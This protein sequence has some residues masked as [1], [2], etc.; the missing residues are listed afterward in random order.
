M[1]DLW[2]T[3]DGRPLYAGRDFP[4]HELTPEKF[5]DFVFA[6]M[7][8]IAG[9][10]GLRI[11][12][13]PSGTG[14]GGFDV[15]AE[16]IDSN[17]SVCIQCKRQKDKLSSPQA[18]DELAKVAARSKLEGANVAEHR[19]ICTG[20]VRTKLIAELRESSRDRIAFLA[21]ENLATANTGELS[22][23][24]KRLDEAGH[25]PREVA[26]SYVRNLDVI[27]AWSSHE[28][29]VSLSRR[30]NEILEIAER[31]FQLETVVRE[32]PRASFDRSAYIDEHLNVRLIIEP[33][34]A[35]SVLPAGVTTT[36]T[37]DPGWHEAPSPKTITNLLEL[38]E[39]E[40]G[41]VA[42]VLGNGGVGKTEALRRTRA[43]ILQA[44]SDSTLPI[45][46]PLTKYIPGHLDR[47]IEQELG[48]VHGTW[49]SLPDQIVILCDGLNECA[50]STARAFL[51]EIEL[52]LK[53]KQVACIIAMR[54]ATGRSKI[55]LPPATYAFVRV[56]S[57]T[58]IGIQHIAEATLNGENADKFL[59]NYRTIADTS[60]SPLLWTPFAVRTALK[61][62]QINAELPASLGAML[63]VLLASRCERNAEQDRDQLDPEV[64]LLLASALAFEALI[65]K[66]QL[67]CAAGEAGRWIQIAKSSCQHA[68]GVSAMSDLQIIELLIAHDL[69]R[70]SEA[71]LYGFDHHLVAGAL[72]APLLAKCWREHLHALVDQ[73]SDDAW[74]FAARLIPSD[75]ISGYLDSLFHSDLI[76]GARAARDLSSNAHQHAMAIL[77]SCVAIGAPE[78]MR[79][80]GVFAL[81][82]L[83][84][85][86][87]IILLKTMADD[88]TSDVFQAARKALAM[89]GDP[90]FLKTLLDMVEI[91]TA[92]P[93]QIS[94]GDIAV[95]QSAPLVKRLDAARQRLAECSPGNYVGESLILIAVERD[96]DDVMLIE[97][98]LLA[99][100]D[101]K[102][103]GKALHALNLVASDRAK[104]AVGVATSG[105]GGSAYKARLFRIA[106][107]AGVTIDIQ[108][109][110]QCVIAYQAA[111]E[112]DPHEGYAITQ[113]IDD[114]IANAIIPVEI[115]ETIAHEL[116][117]STGDRR[118]HLWG[119]AMSCKSAALAD[120]AASCI[121]AWNEDAWHACNYFLHHLDVAYER[122]ATLT[123]ACEAGLRR[124]PE[125]WSLRTE[126]TLALM[127][128][129]GFSEKTTALLS[130][131]VERFHRI[132]EAIENGTLASLLPDDGAML[133]DFSAH[134]NLGL[135]M[136]MANFLP[137]IAQARHALPTK[138]LTDLLRVEFHSKA[139]SEELREALSDQ[140]DDDIDATLTDI[141]DPMTLAKSLVAMCPRGAT[142]TRIK[143]LDHLL[144]T[145]HTHPAIMHQV[146]EAVESCWSQPVLEMIVKAVS[147]IPTWSDFD[148][149][150]FWTF[151]HLVGRKSSNDDE[152]AIEAAMSHAK[153]AFAKRILE[154][155]RVSA[156]QERIGL[157][158]LLP[159]P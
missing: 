92:A 157:G 66:G 138:S 5:E 22:T 88:S 77:K 87:A 133:K 148:I 72:A 6:S 15:Q 143:L 129:L 124:E 45:L 118:A 117:R 8:C 17:R 49:R 110:C 24:R 79:I 34:L 86:E 82:A 71:G 60:S 10:L 139:A 58:P 43:L 125:W 111:P 11:I 18:A 1:T 123:A 107:L 19:F 31:Y 47:V 78:P 69:L 39:I 91:M 85:P 12:G 154:L 59:H 67:E 76:L 73:V 105:D 63:E 41:G 98:H 16:L 103:W 35:P 89:T 142:E 119:L 2:D 4:F 68:L 94:G 99:A 28:F 150:I 23:L 74:V 80:Q 54:D 40:P 36:S 53:R 126:R 7:Q 96:K 152:A 46:F 38:A 137:I 90:V 65:V 141:Q 44:R 26:E 130:S 97:S 153:T 84:S 102:A 14:D 70:R 159:G 83:A 109:A 20:G 113:L 62:W 61:L 101:F 27:L 122:Q 135:E 116:P 114:I 50:N 55:V 115:I 156:S 104:A 57:I 9:D 128:R 151:A 52:L 136:R 108:R 106:S 100:K 37:A 48:V 134:P 121:Q 13:K 149:Q 146:C 93:I 145:A 155:W 95:W 140:I 75:D 120:L 132:R 112:G 131:I 158:R 144:R 64:I 42:V 51:S 3:P 127:A 81:A 25:D 33:R 56:E 21:G 29:N 30:W 147:D 32:F